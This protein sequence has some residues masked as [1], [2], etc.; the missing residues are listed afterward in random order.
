MYTTLTKSHDLSIFNHSS[1]AALKVLIHS[2]QF[3]QDHRII[4][5]KF[6]VLECGYLK[7]LARALCKLVVLGVVCVC[8]RERESARERKDGGS[9]RL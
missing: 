2:L 7:D 5:L 3:L 8:V 6:D 4:A 9:V 1:A